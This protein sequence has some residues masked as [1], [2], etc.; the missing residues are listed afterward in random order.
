MFEK[1]KGNIFNSSTQVLVNT[2]NCVGVMGRGIALECKL[3]FPEMY[4]SYKKFCDQKKIQPGILQIWKDSSPWILNFPTKSDWRDPSKFEY[5]EKGLDKFVKTYSEKGITSIAF[6]L[7]GASLGG[8]PEKKVFELMKNKLSDLKNIDIEVYEYDP[9]AKDDL[10]LKFYQKVYRFNIEEYKKNLNL[11]NDAAIHLK[12]A[13]DNNQIA[14]M[15]SVQDIPKIGIK[16]LENIHNFLNNKKKIMI[17]S[18]LDL[19]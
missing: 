14:S 11:K 5:L 15:L 16:S 8:L 7:L 19:F 13:I 6:P 10:F 2:V 4:K 18:E 17:Q 12:N 1:I 3:R 9:S